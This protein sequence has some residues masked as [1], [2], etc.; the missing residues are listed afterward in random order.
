M[1]AKKS[2]ENRIRGWFPQ[3]PSFKII[4]KTDSLTA[5]LPKKEIGQKHI[6]IANG[7]L[8]GAF[9]GTHAL[10]D[11][12]NKSIGATVVF[13]V[14]FVPAVILLNYWMYRRSKNPKG[15]S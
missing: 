7:L 5:N 6:A 12:S 14:T 15:G 11:P 1:T 4:Q 13:W 9:L 10:F 2:L 8:L 3:E